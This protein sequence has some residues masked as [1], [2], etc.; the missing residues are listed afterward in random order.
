MAS[1]DNRRLSRPSAAYDTVRRLVKN[2]FH[3]NN[4]E[5]TGP[6]TEKGHLVEVDSR[7]LLIWSD[8][9]VELFF[10]IYN[11][12]KQHPE[13]TKDVCQR[14]FTDL[15]SSSDSFIDFCFEGKF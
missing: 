12:K 7:K 1:N 15:D 6:V 10:Q 9:D 14:L 11:W 3:T 2:A 13:A 4:V 8:K 5:M